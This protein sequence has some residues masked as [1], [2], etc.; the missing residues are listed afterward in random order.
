MNQMYISIASACYLRSVPDPLREPFFDDLHRSHSH[1]GFAIHDVLILKID[2]LGL[3]QQLCK[4]L[5]IRAAKVAEVVPTPR[6]IRTGMEHHHAQVQRM[7]RFALLNC[8][9]HSAGEL[10][11]GTQVGSP[12][13][14]SLVDPE[15][16]SRARQRERVERRECRTA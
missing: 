6:N 15:S 14:R 10:N 3:W 9:H 7:T 8:T 12:A 16:R 4:V 13:C 1:A 11:E 5:L 2:C